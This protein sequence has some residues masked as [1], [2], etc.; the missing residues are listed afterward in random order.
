MIQQSSGVVLILGALSSAFFAERFLDL[1]RP[2]QA[3]AEALAY[4]PKGEYLRLASLGYRQ[5]VADLIWL[6]A[7]QHLAL[8]RDTTQGYRW[9][10]HAVDVLTDL[11]P[12]FVAAYQSAGTILGV[13]AGRNEE[14]V[15]I[16][17]KGMRNNPEVWQLPFLIGY[18]YFY[19]QCN[20][21]AS[22]HYLQIAAVLP[23]APEYLSK[24]AS[25]M[26][27]EAGD[28]QAAVEFL[29]RFLRQT[30]DERLR[31][32]LTDRMKYVLQE[33]NLRVLERAVQGYSA[34]YHK[35]PSK[36]EDMVT[37]RIIDE[38]PLDPFGGEYFVD[39]RG[40]VQSTSRRDRL[41]LHQHVSCQW[42]SKPSDVAIQ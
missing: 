6:Q 35:V 29:E 37:A 3:R 32:V 14:S 11:D 34:T 17:E 36:L 25:R 23:G 38:I 4:L 9:T 27:V 19:E 30:R 41:R 21:S 20:P 8:R 26:T 24:L 13:W 42:R 15:A 16:L 40:E 22:A 18:N 5:I 12:K 33:R 39:T 10:Y 2:S 1:E 28:P 7:V 31:E